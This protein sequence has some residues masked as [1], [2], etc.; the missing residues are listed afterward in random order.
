MLWTLTSA[1]KLSASETKLLGKLN[2]DEHEL[3]IHHEAIKRSSQKIG[4]LVDPSKVD[5]EYKVAM[6]GCQCLRETSHEH[7]F[8]LC[9]A[10][11]HVLVGRVTG[12]MGSLEDITASCCGSQKEY[13][14]LGL[15]SNFSYLVFFGWSYLNLQIILRP[16]YLRQGPVSSKDLRQVPEGKFFMRI[17]CQAVSRSAPALLMCTKL[18]FASA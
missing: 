9:G 16:E 6:G 10:R 13:N 18:A 17:C 7:G 2:R 15:A 5:E 12:G 3:P 14:S 1:A 8:V 11:G 4:S